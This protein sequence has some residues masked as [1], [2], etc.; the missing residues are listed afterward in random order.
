MKR[1]MKHRNRYLSPVN[2]ITTSENVENVIK[3]NRTPFLKLYKQLYWHYHL[4]I[5]HKVLYTIFILTSE[6]N[7]FELRDE[8]CEC[9]DVADRVRPYAE[10]RA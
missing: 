5:V 9:L 3:E 2:F 4:Q 10:L 8:V 7:P 1:K 6:K